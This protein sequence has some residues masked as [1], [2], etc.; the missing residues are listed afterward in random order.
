MARYAHIIGWGKAIPRR[1]MTNDDW[2]KLVDTSDEW[3]RS[4]TRVRERHVF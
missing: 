3:I 4:R 1:V 2:A